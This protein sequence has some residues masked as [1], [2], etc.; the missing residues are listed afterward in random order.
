MSPPRKPHCRRGHRM[1]ER[2]S[3]WRVIG[4]YTMRGCRQ[5]LSLTSRLQYRKAVLGWPPVEDVHAA[6]S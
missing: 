6:T 5:C 4:K 2:N 1:T 3:R